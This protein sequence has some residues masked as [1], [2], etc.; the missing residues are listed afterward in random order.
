MIVGENTKTAQGLGK[1]LKNFARSSAK[2]GK[3]SATTLMKKPRR[4]LELGQKLG[5]AAVSQN[6]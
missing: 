3:E 2:N 6:G 1:S 5:T 4:A